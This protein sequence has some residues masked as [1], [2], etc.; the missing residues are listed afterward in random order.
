MK[1]VAGGLEC[2]VLTYRSTLLAFL[3]HISRFNPTQLAVI[4]HNPYAP[5]NNTFKAVPGKILN[6]LAYIAR[7]SND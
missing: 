2:T 7:K 3:D 6:Y 4:G 5:V 1:Y